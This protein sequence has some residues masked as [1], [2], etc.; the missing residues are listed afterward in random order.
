MTADIV[1]RTVELLRAELATSALAPEAA[2]AHQ[3]LVL[4][5]SPGAEYRFRLWFYADG[6]REI[7]AERIDAAGQ[8]IARDLLFWYHPFELPDFENSA[9]SLAGAFDREL[10]GLLHVPTRVWQERGWLTSRLGL[11]REA[12]PGTWESVHQ[13]AA[14]FTLK[15]ARTPAPRH[16]FVA[17]PV[18]LAAAARPAT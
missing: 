12:V 16:V 9:D 7:G 6:D 13:H 11:E 3:R 17:P 10:L 2:G 18:V 14:L 1:G 5:F 4:P 8:A 15:L